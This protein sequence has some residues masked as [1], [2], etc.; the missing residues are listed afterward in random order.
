MNETASKGAMLTGA[1]RQTSYKSTEDLLRA[2]RDLGTALNAIHGL[3]ETLRCCLDWALEISGM[4]CGGIYLR[5]DNTGAIDLVYHVG[6]SPNFVAHSSH[7]E[8][9]SQNVR[10]INAGNPIYTQYDQLALPLE[11]FRKQEN[12]RAMALLPITYEGRVIA[13]FNLADHTLPEIPDFICTI[14]ETAVS[15]IGSAIVRAKMASALQQ[16]QE[17]L[18]ALFDSL[19]DLIFVLDTEG[20]ILQVNPIVIQR[21]GYPEDEL[22]NESVLLLYPPDLRNTAAQ[23]VNAILAGTRDMSPIP[24]QSKSGQ[25]IPVE[26]R[27]TGGYWNN[28]E[29]FF[30]ISR[31]ISER[32]AAEQEIQHREA[33]LKVLRQV[34]QELTA[35]LD[36]DVLLES[37]VAHAVSLM[38]ASRGGL[39]LYRSEFDAMEWV[40]AFGFEHPLLGAF[41]D[42]G[43]GVAGRLL[44]T[45][46]PLVVDNYRQWEGRVAAYDRLSIGAVV[47]APICWGNE[48]LGGIMVEADSPRAFSADDATLLEMFA[49]RTA[50]AIRNASLLKAEREQR[51]FAEALVEATAAVNSTLDLDQVLDCILEQVA[52][53]VPGDACNVML[54]G[55]DDVARM[56]RWREYQQCYGD[57]TNAAFPI[58]DF[59]TLSQMVRNR[60]PLVIVDAVASADWVAEA[61]TQWSRAYVGAPIYI[62][63]AVAGFLNV[64]SAQPGRFTAADAQHLKAFAGHAAVGIEHAHLYRELQDRAAALEQRVRARTIELE[65]Q[66]ARLDAILYSTVDGIV[67]ADREGQFLQ[68]N[69]VAQQWLEHDLA[70]EEATVLQQAIR[71]LAQQAHHQDRPMSMLLELKGLDLELRSAPVLERR[72]AAPGALDTA[73]VVVDIHDVSHL[74]ALERMKTRFITDISHEL[75]TP[76]TAIQLYSH[77]MQQRPEKM[78]EYLPKLAQQADWQVYLVEEIQEVAHLDA[79]RVELHPQSTDLNGFVKTIHEKYVDMAAQR[80]LK[81]AHDL[82]PAPVFA[83]ADSACLE[84]ALDNLML[85]A[86]HYT[87]AC[88]QIMLIVGIMTDRNR[89]WATVTVSDTGVGIPEDELPF[90]FD[91]F[92]RGARTQLMHPGTGLGLAIADK[93]IALHGGRLTVKSPATSPEGESPAVGTAFTIWLPLAKADES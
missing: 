9:D 22:R 24:L 86:I 72:A 48:F 93:I 45:G 78:R 21:L 87:P 62:G 52:R 16:S 44:E 29:A 34:G 60:E 54:V 88:G 19:Q 12:L 41:L 92:F 7:Y 74:K 58:H 3:P 91:R 75:R 79:G 36:L 6:L 17:N 38:G 1:K 32:M 39:Y 65:A 37:I 71:S 67:V 40:V 64:D 26:T 49:T 11:D 69:S 4:S 10:I 15:Q 18:Q 33:Q 73:T 61:G 55:P 5:D 35:Q 31:D 83:Q 46:A 50:I 81:L 42:R 85:N 47:G 20:C 82:S 30:G 8:A 59:A 66:Y 90:L 25:L 23:V 2:Q 13:C 76:V 28:R 53:V 57:T 80:N 56:V 43:E 63:D 89:T 51:A 70:P 27:V 84:H 68:T 14:L 77:L